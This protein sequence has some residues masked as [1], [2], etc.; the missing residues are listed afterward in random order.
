M[1]TQSNTLKKAMIEAL[2]KSL[3]IITT[4]AKS[5]GIDRG[6][7]YKWYRKDK[8]YRASVDDISE[9]SLDFAESKLHQLIAGIVLPETKVFVVQGKKG[10]E[11]LVHEGQKH[12]PPDSTATIF[13]LKCKGKRRGYVEK[14]EVVIS[15]NLSL[16]DLPIT[17][18]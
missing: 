3:G 10:K 14:Q 16:S 4:A 5:V 15:G 17:F 12:Y 7:H 1:A 18:E 13:F 9:R 8:K 11:T 6:T 2:Q